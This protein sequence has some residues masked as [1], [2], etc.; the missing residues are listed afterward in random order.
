M[1]MS[2]L[3]RAVPLLATVAAAACAPVGPNYHR[4]ETAVAERP[5]AKAPFVSGSE[6]AFA[7]TAVPE[8]WWRLYRDPVLDSLVQEAIAANTDLRVAAA[9]IARA[10]AQ[11]TITADA[12]EPQTE[13]GA[14]LSRA[15]P[16]AQE[17]LMPGKEFPPLWI[18]SLEASASYQLDLAGQIRRAIEAAD[19]DLAAT[20]AAYDATRVT[21]V[22]QTTAAYVEAC[23]AGHE[24]GVVQRALDLQQRSTELTRRLV[25]GGRGSSLDVTRS[26]AQEARVRA[27]MP[28]LVAEKQTALFRLATLTGKPPAE[29]DRR[30][31]G[32]HEEPQL[33]SAM[34]I[35]DGAALLRRRPDVRQAELMLRAATARIGVATADLY[36]KIRLGASIGSGGLVDSFLARDTFKFGLGPL[37]SW[38]FP[39]RK[40]VRARIGMAEAEADAA[41][42]RFDGV[43]L[44]ALREVETA[45][46]VYARDLDRRAELEEARTHAAQASRDSQTLFRAG[47]QGFLPVLDADRVLISAEEALAAQERRVAVDQ[48]RLFLALGGGWQSAEV[49]D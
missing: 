1:R 14:G 46:T 26:T 36:P 39:N 29:F 7:A 32:C 45:L 17:A 48:V 25:R 9:N 19:A 43:V 44:T 12:R 37:I 38:E 10:R 27:N 16:S 8:D 6:A 13:L 41:Y 2:M 31:A 4:P 3:R 42:A 34:P 24:I 18:Y 49:T 30:V 40:R 11:R 21:V 28:S 33:E 15:L 20:Q 35:G 23:A 5:S 47:R 22:A